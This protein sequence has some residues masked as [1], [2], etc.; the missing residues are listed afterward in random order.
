MAD[1]NPFLNKEESEEKENTYEVRK[2][3]QKK[4]VTEKQKARNLKGIRKC[5]EDLKKAIPPGR[6]L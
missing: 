3:Y 4:I 6:V 1:N 2:P 5:Q